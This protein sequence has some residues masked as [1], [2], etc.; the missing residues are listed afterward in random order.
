MATWSNATKN[1]ATWNAEE[2]IA[3]TQSFILLQNGGR[4]LLQS[5]TGDDKA[6][7]QGSTSVTTWGNI[8]KS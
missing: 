8:T 1:S 6:L 7:L 2:L 4:L 3:E 5:G